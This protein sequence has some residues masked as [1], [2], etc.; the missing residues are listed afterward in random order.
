MAPQATATAV[1][2][3]DSA[4]MLAKLTQS[5]S[6]SNDAEL[7][8]RFEAMEKQATEIDKIADTQKR[9]LAQ[10]VLQANMEALMAESAKEESDLAQAVNALDQ[11]I[12]QFNSDFDQLQQLN[13]DEKKLISDAEARVAKEKARWFPSDAAIKT[14]EQDV[15]EAKVEAAR[16]MRNRLMTAKFPDSTAV[17]RRR[18]AETIK[19]LGIGKER[20]EVQLK[21]VKAR[22]E[23]AFTI[24]EQASKTA[25]E[26]E[27]RARVVQTD[28]G[29]A[30]LELT[31]LTNGTPEYATQEKKISMLKEQ[32][33]ML[34]GDINTAT[35]VRSSKERYSK[36]LG[37]HQVTQLKLRSNIATW[38]ADLSSEKEE[39]IVEIES[40]LETMKRMS[41][42]DIAANIGKLGAKLQ[43][44][45]AKYMAKAGQVSDRFMLD[46][47]ESHPGQMRD[48][49]E[50]VVA[51]AKAHLD[52]TRRLEVLRA[53]SLRRYGIDPLEGSF[54]KDEQSQPAQPAS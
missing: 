12:V 17:Y 35:S 20:V 25:T 47:M 24:Y 14:A 36:S 8:A 43:L 13:E 33:V 37:V 42:Q 38:I 26:L 9:N 46:R 34:E 3:D 15:E 31:G 10:E 28:L 5:L 30:E 45:N 44:D 29:T 32:L 7:N 23:A 41:D 6:Q 19:I 18:V 50:I 22:K 39:Q 54:L 53:E 11:L 52:A 1:K 51:Q 4:A 27:Q 2:L 16:Q 21:N 40:R 48:L 49:N